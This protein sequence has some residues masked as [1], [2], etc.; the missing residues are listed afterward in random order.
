MRF[1]SYIHLFGYTGKYVIGTVEG[2]AARDILDPRLR[3]GAGRYGGR[4]DKGKHT[5]ALKGEP[6]R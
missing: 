3:G 5:G 4:V 2:D 6:I 1:N